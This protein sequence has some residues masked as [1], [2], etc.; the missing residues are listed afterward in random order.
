MRLILLLLVVSAVRAETNAPVVP[1]SAVVQ[2]GYRTLTNEP[3][4]QLDWQKQQ[5]GAAAVRV[6]QIKSIAE[7]PPRLRLAPHTFYRFTLAEETYATPRAASKRIERLHDM[8]QAVD[9]KIAPEL[10]LSRGFALS[11]RVLI[12]STDVL[13]FDRDELPRI[14]GLLQAELR[15]PHTP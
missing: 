6:Q 11:N 2:W 7:T 9:T 15:Q 3:T 14:L 5:F 8:P 13:A 10:E 1:E 12:V 4:R